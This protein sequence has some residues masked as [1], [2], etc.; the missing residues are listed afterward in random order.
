MECPKK[1]AWKSIHFFYLHDHVSAFV[2]SLLV[3]IEQNG[4]ENSVGDLRC[5]QSFGDRKTAVKEVYRQFQVVNGSAGDCVFPRTLPISPAQA[6]VTRRKRTLYR[7]KESELSSPKRGAGRAATLR[8]V[9][10]PPRSPEAVRPVG[11]RPRVGLNWAI[12]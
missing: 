2:Y 3:C 5:G 1:H 11:D 6:R 8:R 7:K 10:R 9:T 4:D 12:I